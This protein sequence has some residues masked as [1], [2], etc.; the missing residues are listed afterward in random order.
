MR[1][2]IERYTEGQVGQPG[3]DT[4]LLVDRHFEILQFVTDVLALQLALQQLMA[5]QILVAHPV[6][7][8]L[9]QPLKKIIGFGVQACDVGERILAELGVVAIIAHRGGALGRILQPR[10]IKFF[11]ERI[12]LRHAIGDRRRLRE[13]GG[14]QDQNKPANKIS[15]P[16]TLAEFVNAARIYRCSIQCAL[17]AGQEAAYFRFCFLRA[18]YL[19]E[20]RSALAMAALSVFS[21]MRS[22][23]CMPA[24]L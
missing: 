13:H 17:S 8:N 22:L 16:K 20:R 11:E 23:A 18:P 2:G 4:V 24:S 9:F 15:H 21:F 1:H 10:L 7:R 5:E 6:R 14:S 3:V 12:L 19:T